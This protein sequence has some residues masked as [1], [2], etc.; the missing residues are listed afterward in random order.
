M[1]EASASPQKSTCS[2]FSSAWAAA[3]MRRALYDARPMQTQ[4]HTV[5]KLL[6][7]L[8]GASTLAAA[9]APAPA[10]NPAAA[11]PSF[12]A[13][14]EIP[15]PKGFGDAYSLDEIRLGGRALTE[16]QQVERW[17][18]ELAAGRARAGAL[19]GAYLAYRALTA[20]DCD[21]ARN[22]LVKADELG[23]D[24]A[25][26]LLAQ[27][28]ANDTCGPPDRAAREHWLK[29]S[30]PLDYPSAVL[31]LIRFYGVV[32]NAG[33]SAA[34]LPVRAGRRR[35]PG[36]DQVRGAARRLRCDGIAGNGEGAFRGGPQPRRSGGRQDPR[37]DAQASR[38]LRRG[39]A[40]GVRA[41]RRRRQDQLRGL[42]VRLP[43][44]VCH[45]ISRTT[46]AA[47]SASPM[48]S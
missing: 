39:K 22:A 11:G 1:G 10:A 44:R 16:A 24:Q 33:R 20:A 34:A 12:S 5:T 27:L 46:A 30:V 17:Q 37:A 35:L 15:G 28:A 45:G 23:S 40:R 32:G 7:A 14:D 47:R 25:P 13:S 48:S 42:A 43:A 29:K 26:W 18:A 19:V 8:L 3:F 36:I 41:R 2:G 21:A 31:T 38:A 9:Q 6:L 4:V